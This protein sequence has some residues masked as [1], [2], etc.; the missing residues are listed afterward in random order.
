[1]PPTPQLVASTNEPAGN[2]WHVQASEDA[3]EDGFSN[4]TQWQLTVSAICAG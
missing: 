3:D 4:G 1:M 2:G